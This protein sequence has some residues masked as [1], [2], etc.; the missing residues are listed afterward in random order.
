[1]RIICR[2]KIKY[3]KASDC[4]PVGVQSFFYIFLDIMIAVLYYFIVVRAL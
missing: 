4:I 3:R 1:M 2:I